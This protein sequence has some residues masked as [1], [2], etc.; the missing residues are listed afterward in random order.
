MKRRLGEEQRLDE[1][2][3]SG[4]SNEGS[5]VQEASNEE[6][7]GDG[8]NGRRLSAKEWAREAR[9]RAYRAAKARRAADPR[10]AELKEKAKQRRREQYQRAK[11]QRKA[12]LAARSASAK[13]QPRQASAQS[14]LERKPRALSAEVLRI[15]ALLERSRAEPSSE[16]ELDLSAE[17]NV[18]NDIG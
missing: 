13:P 4:I 18:A 6:G 2:I 17:V 7:P 1:S 16:T 5:S 9:R 12:A 11:Q 10:Q 8:G 15:K 14:T 3:V